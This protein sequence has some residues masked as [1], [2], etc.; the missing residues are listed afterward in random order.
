MS[1]GKVSFVVVAYTLIMATCMLWGMFVGTYF[2]PAF[3][4]PLCI[5]VGGPIGFFGSRFIT[6]TLEKRDL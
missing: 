1:F 6:R 4:F 3:I 2:D 5:L